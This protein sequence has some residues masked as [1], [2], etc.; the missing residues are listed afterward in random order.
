M[1]IDYTIRESKRVK[2]V[3]LQMTPQ[4]GLEV[5][6][7]PGFDR[8]RIPEIVRQKQ[9]W[10]AKIQHRIQ[11]QQTYLEAEPDFPTQMNLRAL[12][13][14]WDIKYQAEPGEELYVRTE[15][16]TNTVILR[17]TLTDVKWCHQ[18]LR[19]W[20]SGQGKLHLV[21]WLERTSKAERMPFERTI[22][23]G[24]KT[25][26]GSCS[27]TGTISLNFKLLFLPPHLVRYVLIHEL[28]HTRHMNHSKQFWTLVH[29]R[30]PGYKQAEAELKKAWQY[31]PGW[32]QT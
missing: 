31:V 9:A 8:R 14:T 26:W 13:Q 1:S 15:T 3:K 28:C 23:R 18:G 5:V 22:I 24:Q 6:V 32:L 11:A 19:Q 20:L 25:R 2:H 30:E 27:T 29:E 4:R 12:E 10:I 16:K 7:P 17:G 21:P